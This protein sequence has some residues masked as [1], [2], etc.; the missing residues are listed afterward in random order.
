ME[1]LAG[2][3]DHRHR[4]LPPRRGGPEVRGV[5][6]QHLQPPRARG[7]PGG[8]ARRAGLRPP[9]AR[10]AGAARH[11]RQL[12][13]PGRPQLGPPH[14]PQSDLHQ[15]LSALWHSRPVRQLGGVRRLRRL[16]GPHALDRRADADLV[17]H[18]PAPRVRDRRV[19][20]LRRA[21]ER[22]RLD[23]ADRADRCLHRP[24]RP[25]LRR[26]P[27]LRRSAEPAR[28]GELLAR[29]PLRTRRASSSTS[30][31]RR[32]IRRPPWSSASWPGRLR[33]A[34]RSAVSSRSYPTR[35]GP[36]A[37]AGRSGRVRRSQEVFAAE[38]AETQRT[39][40]AQEVEA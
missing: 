2:A 9:A 28:R 25:R 38:V 35:T 40:A 32:S 30:S 39:Y 21:D 29:D 17:E 8:R 34:P 12:P 4:A 7:H 6:E 11:L 37:S 22:R 10:A 14:R 13:L 36:S 27:A 5:A 31:G 24:G 1:P 33:R 15:E 23:R 3:A 19:P 26:R 18:P 16:P 20:H